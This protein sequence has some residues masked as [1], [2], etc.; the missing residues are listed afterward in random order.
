LVYSYLLEILA[1]KLRDQ[2]LETVIISL[3]SDGLEDGL[4]IF[5]GWGG[6]STEGEEEVSC[7]VL[8][9]EF[10]ERG[11]VSNFVPDTATC[12]GDQDQ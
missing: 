9:F 1:L 5:L 3:D 6:V 11:V 7:E 8:H 4:D 12:E 10:C 2:G